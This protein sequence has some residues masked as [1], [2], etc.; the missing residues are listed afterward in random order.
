MLVLLKKRQSGISFMQIMEI[1]VQNK[2]KSI[3]KS[4]YFGDVSRRQLG[5]FA[6]AARPLL[7]AL[8]CS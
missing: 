6:S 8:A 4:R 1:R 2:R 3:R 7:G 5:M